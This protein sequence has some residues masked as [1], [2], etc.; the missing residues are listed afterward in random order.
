MAE[1][2][3]DV[4]EPLLPRLLLCLLLIK[5]GSI[6]LVIPAVPLLIVILSR[7]FVRVVLP[8]VASFSFSICFPRRVKVLLFFLVMVFWPP[9]ACRASWG[10]CICLVS[11]SNSL[12]KRWLMRRSASIS[13]ILA[14]RASRVPPG[15]R[16]STFASLVL[17]P[18]RIGVAPGCVQS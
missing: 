10:H 16:L 8:G 5:D 6:A 14:C 17:H 1:L 2:L 4:L 18:W 13:S 11:F 9:R 3:L 15:G 12:S 7:G